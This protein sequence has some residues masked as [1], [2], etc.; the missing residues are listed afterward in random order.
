MYNNYVTLRRMKQMLKT[1]V[2]SKSL[3]GE[4]ERRLRQRSFWPSLVRFRVF[5]GL[6]I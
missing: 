2:L 5:V 3:G 1:T 6:H 4:T